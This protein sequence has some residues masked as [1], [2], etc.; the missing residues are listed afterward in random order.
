MEE[1]MG[2]NSTGEFTRSPFMCR[3]SLFFSRGKAPTSMELIG[4]AFRRSRSLRKILRISIHF[5][6]ATGIKPIFFFPACG[7]PRTVFMR[8]R[9]A[10][11]ESMHPIAFLFHHTSYP[12]AT[13][14]ISIPLQNVDWLTPQINQLGR[15]PS[16]VLY[17]GFSDHPSHRRGPSFHNLDFL[18]LLSSHSQIYFFNQI[19]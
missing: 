6:T 14:S 10:I 2:G 4:F 15:I 16:P 17:D 19:L 11:I 8:R 3:T 18:C 7:W 9:Q 1:I 12:L 5:I 13:M